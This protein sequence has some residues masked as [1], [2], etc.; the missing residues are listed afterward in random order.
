TAQDVRVDCSAAGENLLTASVAHDR[1]A[2]T[3]PEADELEASAADR[4]AQRR[5]TGL[6]LLESAA[7]DRRAAGRTVQ[8]VEAAAGHGQADH[9]AA[10][11]DDCRAAAAQ[12]GAARRAARGDV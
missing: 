12:D 7:A 2:G 6:D 9:G 5:P 3:A 11:R 10:G 8:I 4:L 1:G